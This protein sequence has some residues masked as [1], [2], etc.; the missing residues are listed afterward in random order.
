MT[1]P[2]IPQSRTSDPATSKAGASIDKLDRTTRAV[3][4]EMD[5][6][7][8]Y[9][10]EQLHAYVRA[11]G[12]NVTEGRTRHARLALQ[13]AGLVVQHGFGVTSNGAKCRTWRLA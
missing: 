4:S 10:D 1:L 5:P 7:C 13:R 2:T 9:G 8:A 3:L 11:A 6:G 12:L